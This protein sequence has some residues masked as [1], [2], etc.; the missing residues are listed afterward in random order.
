MPDWVGHPLSALKCG[1]PYKKFLPLFVI[2]ALT[3][4]SQTN[5]PTYRFHTNVGDM[6]V[7][8][9][10][11][12]APQTV[13]NFLAYVNAGAYTNTIFHRSVPGF[14]IQG[15][16]YTV[17][18]GVQIANNPSPVKI[19]EN[20]SVV[21][22]FN[23]SN[24]RGTIAMAQP[25]NSPNG[26]TDQWFF[27][28]T[29]NGSQL[30]T[31][32]NG[33]FA[34]F[35]HIINNAGLTIM[36]RIA[37]LPVTDYSSVFGADFS[38]LPTSGTNFVT[39]YSIFPV[40][41]LTA[42]GFQSAASYAASSTTGISPGEFLV[43]Y[44][45]SIGPAILSTLA[46]NN[47]VVST[48]LGGTQVLFNGAPAPMIYTSSGQIS[49]IA[50]YNISDFETINVTVMYNGVAS[51]TLVFPVQPANPAIFTLNASGSGD[52]A[53]VRLDGSIVSA[54]NPA[55]V[56]DILELFGEGYGAPTSATS[57]NDGQIVGTKLPVPADPTTWLLIDG[58]KVDTLYFGG[59]PS[60]VNGVLQVNFKVPS[61]AP[62][63]HQ[64]QLQVGSRKSPAGV[65]LYTK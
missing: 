50:P 36:D 24:T 11:S 62:G 53:V 20:P 10:P 25:A 56:G 46:L 41:T 4:L 34:V 27:N 12:V 55:Q 33:P 19:P 15:G 26:A 60:L 16:G 51:N 31:T 3:A 30:D 22:E 23:V 13:A 2:S 37:A 47:G 8:L 35:G 59:A 14:V 21:N 65:T 64:I 57:L 63:A 52:G 45:Q 29:N 39:V 17:N 54:K 40:P 7:M 32:S 48:N 5:G 58:T 49:C 44:G 61:L 28:L 43:I 18:N 6:D 42:P 38:A 9:T 1:L